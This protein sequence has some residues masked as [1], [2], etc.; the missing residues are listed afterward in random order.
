MDIEA[1]R[2]RGKG[3]G[4]IVRVERPVDV[5]RNYGDLI[6]WIYENINDTKSWTSGYD[7]K[8]I[9]VNFQ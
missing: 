1:Y 2:L 7:S 4:K 3:R 6:L 8:F 9:G 5:L